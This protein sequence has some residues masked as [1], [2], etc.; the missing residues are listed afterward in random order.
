MNEKFFITRLHSGHKKGEADSLSNT[1]SRNFQ[2]KISS[3]CVVGNATIRD[4]LHYIYRI[5]GRSIARK[6]QPIQCSY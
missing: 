6:R 3:S 5:L 4:Q 1:T 2:R